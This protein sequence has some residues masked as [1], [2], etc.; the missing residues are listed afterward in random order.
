GTDGHPH[1]TAFRFPTLLGEFESGVRLGLVSRL[2]KNAVI[3]IGLPE[4]TTAV[5]WLAGASMMIRRKV[6][7]E[8]GLFDEKFFLYYEET[9]LCR[10]AKK[11]NW[12]THYLPDSKVAHIGSASTGLSE[13][14]DD[15][16]EGKV[17]SVRLP[18]YWFESRAYYYH[19]HYGKWYLLLATV[20]RLLGSALFSLR[21]RLLP[22]QTAGD[23]P[24]YKSDLLKNTWRYLRR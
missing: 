15:A 4:Q 11:A 20:A 5:D 14:S 6:I 3:P 1:V 22:T 9:D 23:P 13:S 24:H 19:K 18:A 21:K 16:P 17:D 7:E 12:P 10:R 2:L 8:V